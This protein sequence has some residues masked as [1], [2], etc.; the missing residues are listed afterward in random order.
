[1]KFFNFSKSTINI[2]IDIQFHFGSYYKGFRKEKKLTNK[3]IGI[4][5]F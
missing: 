3:L 4:S 5:A 1:M 2:R